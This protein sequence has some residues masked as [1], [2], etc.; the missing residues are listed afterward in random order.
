MEKSL[1]VL[2]LLFTACGRGTTVPP[3]C[4]AARAGD[5]E[6]IA[7]LLKEGENVNERGGVNDWTALMHAVHKDQLE[8]VRALVDAGA[9]INATAGAR[10]KTTALRLAETQDLPD[11]AG[12]LREQGA[13]R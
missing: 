8:A 3:L 5:T 9:D 13:R 1:L 6:K 11:I 4:S 10:G 2:V 7:Q 12:F